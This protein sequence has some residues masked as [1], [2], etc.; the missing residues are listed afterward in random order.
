[1]SKRAIPTAQVSD[2][3]LLNQILSKLTNLENTIS[4]LV[5]DKKDV[6]S[7]LYEIS[8]KIKYLSNKI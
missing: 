6:S 1:M 3:D 2:R 4:S 5:N 7:R 8:D